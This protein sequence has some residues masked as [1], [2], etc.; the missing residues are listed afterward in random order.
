M[1]QENVKRYLGKMEK[2][3]AKKGYDYLKAKI[4]GER[5]YITDHKGQTFQVTK[6]IKTEPIKKKT[7]WG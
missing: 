5:I 4:E 7:I 3:Y 1:N 2:V 6:L